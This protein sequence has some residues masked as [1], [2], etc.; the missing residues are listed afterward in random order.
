MATTDTPVSPTSPTRGDKAKNAL[1][2]VR[3]F[4][5][6]KLVVDRP[7]PEPSPRP[8]SP[9]SQPDP[10]PQTNPLPQTDP[11]SQPSTSPHADTAPQTEA[12]QMA[13]AVLKSGHFRRTYGPD[14]LELFANK[15]MM[16][17]R[18]KGER[19]KLNVISGPK[20]EKFYRKFV[21]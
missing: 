18:D 16:S 4:L 11:A 10:P 21:R 15:Y 20:A 8:D 5:E 12:G 1:T 2:G 13:L 14:F 19:R 9:P 3:K 7:H 6:E 17:R